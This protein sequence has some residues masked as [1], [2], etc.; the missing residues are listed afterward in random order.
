[1]SQAIDQNEERCSHGIGHHDGHAEHREE[2]EVA[3]TCNGIEKSFKFRPDELVRALLARA[4]QA[5][6]VV[7]NPHTYGLYNAAGVEL[8][9]D[10]TLERAGV[11]CGDE[12]LLRPSTVRAG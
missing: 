3:V 5:F 2:R 7:N 10:F 4:L 12:L 8:K 11:K 1:M 9:D 6:N